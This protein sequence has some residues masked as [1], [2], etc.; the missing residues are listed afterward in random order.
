MSIK[1]SVVTN[2]LPV[3]AQLPSYTTG[4]PEITAYF[5]QLHDK[6]YQ[7]D[8]QVQQL[9]GL[10]EALTARILVLEAQ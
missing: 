3:P 6:I 1:L 10:S 5:K 4:N 2:T 9:V 8:Q 7:L